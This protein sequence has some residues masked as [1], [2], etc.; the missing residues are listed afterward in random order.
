MD[1]NSQTIFIVSTSIG[2]RSNNLQQG[3]LACIRRN[4]LEI[5]RY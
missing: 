2:Y 4:T 5:L 3:A 1:E